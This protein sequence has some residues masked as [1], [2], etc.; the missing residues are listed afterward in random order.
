M[1]CLPNIIEH[2]QDP[3]VG[4]CFR[5]LL[6]AVVRAEQVVYAQRMYQFGLQFR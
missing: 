5:Q 2:E 3:F 6:L 1:L 4:Q